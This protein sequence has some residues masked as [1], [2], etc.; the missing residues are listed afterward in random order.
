MKLEFHFHPSVLHVLPV[1]GIQCA[2]CEKEDCGAVHW[3][4]VTGWLIFTL[5][6]MW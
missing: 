4:L 1:L 3:C 6:V 2:E 5:E